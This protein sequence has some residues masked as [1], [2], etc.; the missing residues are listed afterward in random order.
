VS[1]LRYLTAGESHGPALTGILEGLPAGLPLLAEDINRDLARRQQGYG[2]GGRMKIEQDTAEILSGIRFG[3]TLGSPLSL[4]IRNRDFASWSKRMQADSGGP[5][6]HPVTVPRP[7]H[8]DLAGGLKY[9]HL[10]DLRNVLERASARETAIRVALGGAA[11]ALLRDLGIQIGSFVRSIGSADGNVLEPPSVSPLKEDAES[12]AL[13]ADLTETRALDEDSSR[14]FV[15]AIDQ[16]RKRRDTL[17]GVAEILATGV[18]VGLGSH[19]HWD[20]K[21][22]GRIAQA[23]MSIPAIKAVELGEGWKAARSYGSQTHDPIS[24]G[25]LGLRRTSNNAGGLEGGVTNGQPLVIR[26]AM[27]PIATVPAA[28]PSVDLSTLQSVP[29]HVER[30]DTCAVPAAGVIA[31]SILALVLADALLECLGGDTMSS[32]RAP[33]ARLRIAARADWGQVFLLGPMGSGKSA[34]GRVIAERLGRRWVDLDSEIEQQAGSSVAEIFA[35]KGEAEF[36]SLEADALVAA[37]AA[38]SSS[39]IALGGGAA[40]NEAAWRAMRATGVTFCLTAR[41]EE[42]MRRL[43]QSN[44]AWSERPMLAGRDPLER[45]RELCRVRQPFYS[46]ADLCL[47]TEGLDPDAAA[48]AAIGMLRSLR[49]PIAARASRRSPE[50]EIKKQGDSAPDDEA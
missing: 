12:L 10:D 35:R 17:G 24:W 27:K 45:L 14:R 32:L 8:A 42:L 9:A 20:R 11:R 49:S 3:L 44:R 21:L 1:R 34:V 40:Q 23:M 15:A 48:L 5:D 18:P 19:V 4:L 29:A 50:S 31:E 2:R 43:S 41:P 7:G 26:I 39:V 22:D 46:R 33:M 30:S 36:R 13:R 25:D 47:D 28:L 16:A 6:P 38:P 37:A